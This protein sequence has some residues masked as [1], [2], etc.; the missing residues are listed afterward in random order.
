MAGDEGSNRLIALRAAYLSTKDR[1]TLS[2]EE[3]IK[4]VEEWEVIPVKGGAVLIKEE[5][6]HACILPEAFGRWITKGLI[7]KTLGEVLRKHGRAITG[8]DTK[9]GER[10]V[11]RL[12]FRKIE[13][14]EGICIWE[15]VLQS[16]RE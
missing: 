11:E 8:T 4:A 14:K 15:L 13:E 3:F 16:G 5:Q 9:A 6:I 10:F 1:I 7:R 12:G 2:E